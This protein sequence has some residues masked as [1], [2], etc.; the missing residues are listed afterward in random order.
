MVWSRLCLTCRFP[1]FSLVCICWY[2]FMLKMNSGSI[3][4]GSV[5]GPSAVTEPRRNLGAQQFLQYIFHPLLRTVMGCEILF[6]PLLML[7]PPLTDIQVSNPYCFSRP[8]VLIFPYLCF[9]NYSKSLQFYEVPTWLTSHCA[10]GLQMY[11]LNLSMHFCCESFLPLWV[12][13]R[14]FPKPF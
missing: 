2:E 5:F 8:V 10:G 4:L 14:C 7:L 9:S 3:S 6:L 12:P 1:V 11:F 13:F